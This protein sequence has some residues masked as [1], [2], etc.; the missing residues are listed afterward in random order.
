MERIIEHKLKNGIA[1][2]EKKPV[3]ALGE[4]TDPYLAEIL[5]L[6]LDQKLVI[7]ETL[8]KGVYNNE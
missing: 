1:A 8:R 3:D 5:N 2:V 4:T 7:L 6:T